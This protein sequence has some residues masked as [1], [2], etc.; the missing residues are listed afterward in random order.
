MQVS[1][2]NHERDWPYTGDRY[3]T[4]YNSGGECGVPYERRFKMPQAGADKPWYSFEMGPVHFTVMSVEHDF[5]P[6][7]EQHRYF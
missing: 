7:S 4:S 6:G 3:D 5:R 2:G 1:I